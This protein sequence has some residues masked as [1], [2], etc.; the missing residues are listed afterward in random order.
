MKK[1]FTGF[2]LAIMMLTMSVFTGCSLI[3]RNNDKYYNAIV[4]SIQDQDNNTI[5]INKRELITAYNSYGYNYEQYYGK[6]RKEAVELTLEQLETRKLTIQAAE[7]KFMAE[8]GNGEVLKTEEKDYLWH[9]T[10]DALEDNFMTYLNQVT[11]T[12]SSSNNDSSSDDE[13]KFNGYTKKALLTEDYQIKKTETIKDTLADY[14]V[15]GTAKDI[16]RKEDKDLIY[17][18][19]LD[20]VK[21][22]GNTYSQA[23]NEYRKALERSE[24]GLKKL[25]GTKIADRFSREIDRI[26]KIVYENFIVEKYSDSFKDSNPI[27]DVTV[28]QMLD[29]Y[30]GK[31]MNSYTQYV[32]EGD[33]DYEEDV[34]S[35]LSKIF[36]FKNGDN[37]TKFYTVAHILFKFSDESSAK[38]KQ[39][40]TDLNN[41]KIT[42][43]QYD[44][45]IADLTVVPTVRAKDANGVYNEVEDKDRQSYERN[46]NDLY[47]HI[48]VV[49]E[50]AGDGIAKAEAFNEFIYKYNEDPGIMNAEYNYVMGVNKSQAET[51]SDSEKI[52]LED[53]RTYKSYSKMVS[54]FTL[55]GAELYNDGYGQIGDLSGLVM[56][57]NGFHILMYTGECKN[58]F[59]SIVEGLAGGQQFVLGTGAI[60]TLNSARLNVCVDKTIFDVLYEEL[61]KD[62]FSTFESA[63]ATILRKNCKFTRY[64]S[65]YK[66]L[67]EE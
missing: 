31:V 32:L 39:A 6:T 46:M 22:G 5:T 45:I 59:D 30:S 38:Y 48:K 9:E 4:A 11:G 28:N 64:E 41:K 53:G 50:G 8:N 26:Y 23:F 2:I 13:I 58:Y 17:T 52:T 36:Y 62:N 12:S 35:D 3:T 55:A 47:N 51:A 42:Q 25:D 34:L 19:L 37:D 7:K 63:H 60:E 44:E 1:K 43:S 29:L 15:E 67:F 57:E 61:A 40:Q 24:E 65:E 10:N 16:K 20:F 27:S 56:T 66:D 33:E 21:N 14:V 54:E 18:N 49:V